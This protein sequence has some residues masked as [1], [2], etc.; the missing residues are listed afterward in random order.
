MISNQM[1]WI[2]HFKI[3]LNK[4][5]YFSFENQLNDLTL[6]TFLFLTIEKIIGNFILLD[7]GRGL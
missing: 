4:D 6:S 2:F 1:T 7:G 5:F 3:Y